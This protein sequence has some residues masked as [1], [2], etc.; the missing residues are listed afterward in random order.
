MFF[1]PT[2]LAKNIHKAFHN[3]TDSTNTTSINLRGRL[4]RRPSDFMIPLFEINKYE[5]TISLLVVITN[6]TVGSGVFLSALSM[7][8]TSPVEN[9][10]TL[11]LDSSVPSDLV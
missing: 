4:Q 7:S 8:E 10:D 9:Y 11:K 3:T 5:R 6:W 2:I 1:D